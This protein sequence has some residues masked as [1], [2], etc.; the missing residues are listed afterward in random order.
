MAIEKRT[1]M[2]FEY[3]ALIVVILFPLAGIIWY[4]TSGSA[5]SSPQANPQA[6]PTA[7]LTVS[8]VSPPPAAITLDDP[9]ALPSTVTTGEIVPFS[10]TI[11]NTGSVAATYTYK[12]YVIWDSG[13]QD[14]LDENSVTI[15]AGASTDLSESLKFESAT[16]K[17]AVY[18]QVM[19]PAATVHFAIP[20]TN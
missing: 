11:E 4:L 19:N 10:F 7:A 13:E 2:I 1:T 18:I 5:Q 9:S 20:R 16:A 17:G 8:T 6:V 12:V 14:V 3:A 15:Q